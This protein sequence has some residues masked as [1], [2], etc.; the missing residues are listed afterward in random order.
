YVLAA[1]FL[2][3]G[4]YASYVIALL[5]SVS[6]FVLVKYTAEYFIFLK[7][8]IIREFNGITV[9]DGLSNLMLYTICIAS[10]SIT[11]LFKRWLAGN[12]EIESLESKQ[13]KNSI[14]EIKNSIQPTFLYAT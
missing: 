13:L 9:L 4:E 7:A 3:E 6:G 2:P 14:E 8:D 10:G 11:L 1:R 12:A 5:I